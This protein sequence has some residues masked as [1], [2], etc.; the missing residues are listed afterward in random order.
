MAIGFFK[1]IPNIQY[2]F[3][4]DGKFFRAKDMFR[5]VSV[6]SYLQEGVSGYNYYRITEG[7][8]PDIVASRLYGDATLYWTFFL[9]NENLQDLNDWPKSNQVFNKFIDRKYSGT[10]LIAD[11]STDIVSST[12]SKWKLG[13]KVLQTVTGAYGFITEVNPT[14]NRITLNSV[15]GTFTTDSVVT[16][17]RGLNEKTFTVSSVTR[18]QDVINHYIDSNDFRTTV[19]TGNSP[20]T[21]LQHELVIND[22]KHLI[23]YIEPKHINTIVNEFKELVRD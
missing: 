9:V 1:N 6:W 3:N 8:R 4:S 18:E 14:H 12:T 5:K 13:E 19:S 20:V 11:S 2:D 10:C 16:S 22:D 23:R 21:N 7:E 15:V 17:T